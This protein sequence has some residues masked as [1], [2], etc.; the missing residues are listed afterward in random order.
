[1]C[2]KIMAKADFTG[3]CLNRSSAAPRAAARRGSAGALRHRCVR[4]VLSA[5]AC[6]LLACATR[7]A[8]AESS[9]QA[10]I[11][12]HADGQV[13]RTNRRLLA[14]RE[15]F[16]ACSVPACPALVRK[17]CTDLLERVQQSLP[18]VVFV[19][20]DGDKR[21]VAGVRVQLDGR[22]VPTRAGQP[23]PVDPGEH[24]VRFEAPDGQVRE[25]F[26]VA[27][28][29][30]RARRIVAELD[31]S[32]G[33]GDEQGTSATRHAAY[34]LGGVGAVALGS[35]GYFALRGRSTEECAPRCTNDEVDRLRGQYLAADVS[36]IV[37]LASLGAAAYLFVTEPNRQPAHALNR[38]SIR[39]GA[40]PTTRGLG[41]GAAASF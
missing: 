20:Y 25:Y 35:F 31:G 10:C 37:G 9:V 12:A 39:L 28:E 8:R 1:M 19:A 27:R 11:A 32:A 13:L 26:I 18:T 7:T 36:L 34:V 22:A 2:S 3:L 30:E 6:A 17:D 38:P 4:V 41:F 33:S 21:E 23:T 29:N 5:C 14:A 15:Q 24:R 16:L 40:L